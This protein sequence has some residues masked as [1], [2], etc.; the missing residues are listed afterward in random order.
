[1]ITIEGTGALA[2]VGRDRDAVFDALLAGRT[3]RARLRGFPA[4]AF[5]AQHAYEVDDRGGTGLDRPGRASAW[6]VAAVR[7]ALRDAGLEPGDAGSESAAADLPVIV[8]TGLGELRGV[9]LWHAGQA[10]AQELDFGAALRREF[11][12]TVSYTVT[13]ACSASLYAL[14]MAEDL[15]MLGEHDTVVV[16][17]VDS[18]TTSMYGLLDRVQLEPPEALVPFGRGRKGVLMGEGAAAVVLRRRDTPGPGGQPA[19]APTRPLARPRSVARLRSVA[20]SCDARHPTAPDAKGI[21]LTMRDAQA[22]A[23]LTPSDIDVVYAHGTGTPLN[24]EAEGCALAS[25]FR[26]APPGP[27]ITAIKSM[28][29]HTSGGSGLLSLVMALESLRRGEVPPVGGLAEVI[30][31]VAGLRFAGGPG[32][33]ETRLGPPVAI[34][35]GGRPVRRAQIDAFGFG[36]V[37]AVAVVEYPVPEPAGSGRPLPAGVG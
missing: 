2:S 31:E 35:A 28:T 9:E 36:G 7:A 19:P 20:L 5:R 4:R 6:L 16:A 27:T 25:V 15:L 12:T 11:G 22:R 24:D 21:E 29:G 30:D 1:M 34:D 13:N 32:G 14:A 8:G 37:N 3:G 23:G 17:G 10:P 33:G 18:I 26:P